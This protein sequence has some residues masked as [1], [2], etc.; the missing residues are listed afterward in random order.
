MHVAGPEDGGPVPIGQHNDLTPG[1]AA[2]LDSYESWVRASLY[3]TDFLRDLQWTQTPTSIKIRVRPSAANAPIVTIKR[4]SIDLLRKQLE[5]V[6]A[7]L[8]Q[9]ADR[10]VEIVTQ[11]GFP[12]DY[13]ASILGLTGARNAKTFELIAL[14]QVLAAHVAML[15][16]HALACRR[17]DR[18]SASVMPMLPTPGHPT[19]PSAHATEAFAVAVV[20]EGLLSDPAVAPFFPHKGRTVDLLYKL[21]ERIAVNRT[22]AGVHFPV[23][24][25]A[26]AAL[27]EAVG[28][29]ILARCRP[30]G[31]VVPRSFDPEDIDFRVDQFRE[32]LPP[33]GK[34]GLKRPSAAAISYDPSELFQW[35]WGKTVAEYAL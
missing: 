30:G 24:T 22:V 19:F 29:L 2:N 14:T 33:A 8:D 21:A 27:G 26:G 32:D 3:L 11:V 4:P 10:L 15:T 25:W 20:L 23:D 31:G 6:R 5:L 28:Q 35:L 34:Y 9:R 1:A 13:F 18:L 16:K 12:T 7:Y 17:P